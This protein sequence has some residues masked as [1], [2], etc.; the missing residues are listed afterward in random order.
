MRTKRMVRIL[1]IVVILTLLLATNS[2]LGGPP[3]GQGQGSGTVKMTGTVASK[4]SYQ[5]RLTDAAGNP[6][7][8]TYNLVFQIW[9]DATGG[10]QVGS[11][12]V[13]N[14]VPVRNGLFT[15]ELDVPQDTFNG[16][17]LWLR[18]QVNGQWLSPR[19]ELLP[20][21]Y[22][23]SLRPGA[24]IKGNSY[25]GLSSISTNSY[26]LHGVSSSPSMGAG[27]FG[28]NTGGA[29]D[30]V[31]ATSNG[32]A[33]IYAEGTGANTYGGYFYSS[34]ADGVY[35]EAGRH[36]V[37]VK[38]AGAHGV[39]VVSAGG[40]GVQVYSANGN[41]VRVL[42]AGHD[43][44]H[45]DSANWSGV[46]VASASYDALRVGGAGRDGLAVT[47]ATRHGV[48]V[49]NVG[50]HGVDVASANGNGVQVYSAGGIGVRVVSA[51]H[52]GVRVDSANES[53]VSVHSAGH[54]GVRIDS[55]NW[56]GVYVAS[57]SYDALRVQSAGQDGL[58]IFESVGR[59]YIR[60]GSDADPDF[61]VLKTG[62][63]QSDVG[64]NTPASD[65]AEM[66]AVQGEIANYEPGDVLVISETQ[67]RTVALSSTPYSRAVIGVYSTAPGFVGG[68]P[69]SDEEKSR[70][71]P[72]AVLGIVPCKVSTEN[73]PI[74]RGDLLVTSSTPGHAMRADNP[75]PGTILGKALEPLDKG[76]GT[77]LVLVTLQ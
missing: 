38:S 6:L 65:F 63:V 2:S 55:A 5:G 58:R 75:P 19:Q 72:V 59:D 14:N 74:R 9:D 62:E 21:P 22:A 11:N 52:D 3:V 50:A 7:N 54:D 44:V 45:V 12:I 49:E 4:I 33:G 53:G 27:V 13:K 48:H 16:R 46:Y 77:I 41:G 57:A 61:R 51:G 1:T 56:S 35:V 71:I 25:Y 76:T 64:F 47:A 36:G 30:G 60:A 70:D 66:M 17:A 39:D 67:D 37:Y 10:S 32:R 43:G 24:T 8:G 15:V 68:H 42:S 29:G 73:G 18:I 69:V 23:L 28:E 40:D 26:G 20:V 34:N 31:Q